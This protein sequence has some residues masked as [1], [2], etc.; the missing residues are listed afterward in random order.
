MRKSSLDKCLYLVLWFPKDRLM[1][2]HTEPNFS[3]HVKLH[4]SWFSWASI[5]RTLVLSAEGTL[6]RNRKHVPLLTRHQ[7]L[8]SSWLR[9][10]K[11]SDVWPA[12]W[13]VSK[14]TGHGGIRRLMSSPQSPHQAMGPAWM[15]G[16]FFQT[17]TVTIRALLK[18]RPRIDQ[19]FSI[20]EK[21]PK[22]TILYAILHFVNVSKIFNNKKKGNTLWEFTWSWHILIHISGHICF[23]KIRRVCLSSRLWWHRYLSVLI[24]T[25]ALTL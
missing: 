6:V 8:G 23:R 19:A 22:F 14:G 4:K 7:P 12:W 3:N 16:H 25:S 21:T 1:E 24:R 5:T 17:C 18:C 9:L 10:S 15:K 2:T 20:F 11:A 13:A